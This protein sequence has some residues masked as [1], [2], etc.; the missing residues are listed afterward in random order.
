MEFK[1][2]GSLEVEG[3]D[4][5]PL[6]VSG[7]KRRCLLA[8][9]LIHANEVLSTD[10][11]IDTLWGEKQISE[12]LNTLRF[13]ISKLRSA[14]GEEQDRLATRGTGYVLR[15]G[16]EEV[17]ARRFESAVA[18][19]ASLVG[20]NPEAAVARYREALELWRGPAL[21]DFEYEDFARTE[22]ARLEELRLTAVE[23]RL[24][25]ELAAGRHD[26]LVGE[27]RTLVG[28]HPLRERLWAAL[29]TS[30][31]RSGRQAEALRAYQEARSTLG[32]ELG[33]EPSE[34][35]RDLEEKVLLQDESIKAP[36]AP[37][38]AHNLPARVG[39]FVGRAG[40][41][42]TIEKL[43]GRNRLVTLVGVGGV[44]KTSLALEI[45]TRHVG[46][47]ADGV[48]LIDLSTAT[49]AA[50]VAVAAAEALGVRTRS[51]ERAFSDTVMR[52]SN[53]QALLVLDNCEHVIA[54]AAD[55]AAKLLAE[56]PAV[57]ILATSR[58]LLSVSGEITFGVPPMSLNQDEVGGDAI[59]LFMERVGDHSP[60]AE[61]SLAEKETV[62]RICRALDGLPLAIELAAARTRTLPFDEVERRLSARFALLAGG[63]RTAPTRQR[64]LRG[65][66][67]WSYEL[68]ADPEKRL[69]GSLSVIS[70]TFAADTVEAAVAV[71]GDEE[72]ALDLL[73]ALV[74]K[75]LV[76]R[77]GDRYYLLPTLRR[78]AA[79]R[80]DGEL[81]PMVRR[82][83]VG[84]FAAVAADLETRLLTGDEGDGE[85]RLGEERSN[86]R[87]AL[88]WAMDSG[89][90][91]AALQLAAAL[92]L[93]WTRSGV[94]TEG[95]LRR[96]ASAAED[97]PQ[98]VQLQEGLLLL[99]EITGPADALASL[100]ELT[101]TRGE[102]Q[103]ATRLLSAAEQVRQDLGQ[104]TPQPEVDLANRLAEKL[105][106]EAFGNAWR[107]G[108]NP[109]NLS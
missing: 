54:P 39:R 102:D 35:L 47:Y 72:T 90:M 2:L 8:L 13:Q 4:G 103:R 45:A 24:E 61:V 19:A 56:C 98:T 76:A 6:R 70:G 18:E 20:D 37:R 9:F 99:E 87:S 73:T 33:I 100:A 50:P 93:Y 48:W 78:Y 53:A 69:F 23:G 57:K 106:S 31:Y 7:P 88:A 81:L 25:A 109:T 38:R 11:I 97:A 59:A 1:I 74:D 30:L 29:M 58:E 63:S 66:M 75:S 86:L 64:T 68:L 52:M 21:A 82:A 92:A 83:L 36:D 108:R 49:G 17:D 101:E 94:W 32:D 62:Y 43:L 44:G 5:T 71:G 107:N 10:R 12:A 51:G 28:R 60:G 3:A 34:G 105:G 67:D 89:D 85:K 65:T 96:A 27:L 79:E 42:S 104:R 95:W 84:H 15:V 26:E 55:F 77:I 16:P 80:M 91:E 46:K 14:L 41:L 40:E 22:I